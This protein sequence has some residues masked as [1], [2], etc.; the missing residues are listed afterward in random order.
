MEV[1]GYK[2]KGVLGEGRTGRVY[3]GVRLADLSDVA[4][5]Q[6]KPH[7]AG[8]PGVVE[9]VSKLAEDCAGFQHVSL[10]PVLQ[11]FSVQGALCVVEPLIEGE[12]LA[13]RLERGVLP[14]EDAVSLGQQLCDALDELH[15]LGLHHGD[16]RPANILLT[17][18]GARLVGFGVADRTRRRRHQRAMFGDAFDAP[19]VRDGS[20][21]SASADLF[22]LAATLHRALA[23]EQEWSNAPGGEDNPL[24]DVL[25]QGMAPTPMMRF[26]AAGE[27]RRQLVRGLRHA[28]DAERVRIE[29]ERRA[30]AEASAPVDAPEPP[31]MPA[32]APKAAL[33][34]VAVVV[35]IAALQILL[36][37]LPDTPPGMFEVAAGAD[38]LGDHTG[39]RDERPGL[40]WPHERYFLDLRETTVA[41]YRSC[42]EAGD[43]TGLGGRLPEGWNDLDD[44]PVVGATWLQ[45]NGYCQWAGKRLPSENE[46]EAA[47]RASGGRY[48]WGDEPPD[49]GRAHYGGDEGGAC[50]GE[51][52]ARPRR[53]PSIEELS[54]P[55]HLAGNVWEY[56]ASAYEATR[57]PGS[58]TTAR[59]GSSPL[60]TIKGGAWSS[61][62]G[63]LRGSSRL[64]V[65]LDHWAADLGFRCAADPG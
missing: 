62:E 18:R 41:E 5:R 44:L 1:E 25:K 58:G 39:P 35:L 43:C 27:M 14:P 13:F 4:F 29:S 51:A 28:E 46:W 63:E 9:A 56:T 23:G 21:G 19:E 50:A 15:G 6:V 33:G 45:A 60:R 32:W 37:L 64:G 2:L 47:V 57:G 53:L 30:F 42:V 36:S 49:C 55:V 11:S 48:P 3:R 40:T 20:T 54:A 34:A 26:P 61:G 65:A 16:I 8:E 22:A 10:V 31:G 52:T 59:S 12:S 38:S 17:G 24:L 7:L